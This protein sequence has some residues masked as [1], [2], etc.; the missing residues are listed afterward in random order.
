MI[1]NCMLFLA[2]MVGAY[3]YADSAQPAAPASGVGPGGACSSLSPDQ[4][5]F[6]SGLKPEN[7]AMF[8]AKF[9]DEMRVA[10]MQMAMQTDTQGKSMMT[11]DQATEKMARDY[12]IKTPAAG[13][14]PKG[15][16]I[17]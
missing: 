14:S 6:A 10:C 4:Q 1:K 2:L 13:S 12:Q 16:P 8:C 9:T 15:C 7:K 5:A 11:P 17:K 3:V